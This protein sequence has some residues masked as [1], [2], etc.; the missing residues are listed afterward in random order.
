MDV[1]SY[2]LQLERV[3]ERFIDKYEIALYFLCFSIDNYII[4]LFDIN[5]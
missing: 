3:L 1:I 4:G 5:K 2:D